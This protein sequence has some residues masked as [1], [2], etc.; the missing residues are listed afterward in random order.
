M[1][2]GIVINTTWSAIKIESHFESQGLEF[3]LPTACWI[4]KIAT[5]EKR[6]VV[7]TDVQGLSDAKLLTLTA[8]NTSGLDAT[9]I[10]TDLSEEFADVTTKYNVYSME[11]LANDQRTNIGVA[12]VTRD[13]LKA[14]E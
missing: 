13:Q 11:L 9:M 12:T 2:K 6:T 1:V 5:Y 10:L 8:G 7:S 14:T 3:L 4:H